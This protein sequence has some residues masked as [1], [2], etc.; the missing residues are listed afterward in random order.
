VPN[1]IYPARIGASAQHP[2]GPRVWACPVAFV[3]WDEPSVV[4]SCVPPFENLT[5]LAGL[6][7]GCCTLNIT[8]ADIAGETSLQKLLESHADQ[9]PI[10]ACLAPGTYTLTEPLVLGTGFN[11]LTLEACGPGVVLQAPSSPGSD[12]ILGLIVIEGASSVTIRGLELTVPLVGFSPA[13]SFS[14][15]PTANEELL[16]TFARGLQVAIGISVD[17]STGLTVEDC[18]FEFP[19]PGQANTFGAGIYA[20]GAMD[21]VEVTGCTF[22]SARPPTKVPF[23]D[24][25]AGTRTE[26]Y[27]LTFGYLQVPS[28]APAATEE[29][30][31]QRLSAS[32]A[33]EEAASQR[34]QDATIEQ[35]LFQGVTVAT[36]VMAQ[37]GTLRIDKN[38]VRNSYGGFWFL[39]LGGPSWVTVYDVLAGNSDAYYDLAVSKA[40]A[41]LDPIFM[42]AT[43]I[44]RVLPA[45]PPAGG[46]LVP[47]KI[48]TPSTAELTLARRAFSAKVTAM[49]PRIDAIFTNLGAPGSAASIPAADTGTSVSLRLDLCD[50]QVDSIIADSYSGAGLFV[51]DLTSGAGSALL[52]GSRIRSRFPGGE[53]AFALGL[54]EAA[55]TGNIVA[56]EVPAQTVVRS[57]TNTQ[58]AASGRSGT[59]YSMVL[60]AATLYDAP[61][62][63]ITGNVFIDPTCLLPPC[64]GPADWDTLNTVINWTSG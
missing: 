47:R 5:G 43:A 8:P 11:D 19:D 55:I 63:A 18:T 64:P 23:Y 4:S 60:N 20:T 59:S 22:Q 37:L 28:F 35:C 10:T 33:S 13:G 46:P 54:G 34:L 62:V 57:D 56:N 9:G 61:A 1:L 49:P 29:A 42:L 51:A 53:T 6:P 27:Q 14:G 25:A 24:L 2:D 58:E 39:S 45:T 16:E 44:G 48:F 17:N 38:T 21:G 7:R 26:P 40:A 36:L 12:F 30:E 3:T 32:A 31:S 41:L 50:C 52:H 15:L